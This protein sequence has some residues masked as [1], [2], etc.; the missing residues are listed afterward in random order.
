MLNKVI[1]FPGTFDPFHQGHLEIIQRINSKYVVVILISNNPKKKSVSFQDRYIQ[2]SNFLSLNNPK[3]NN[4]IIGINFGL[5]TDFLTSLNCNFI[6]R[7][8]RN[9]LDLKYEKELIRNYKQTKR[10]LFVKLIKSKI[11]QNISSSIL[12]Q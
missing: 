6:L 11:N 4:I 8:Y 1:V 3:S 7:G 5:T 9:K 12:K 2:I 10:K